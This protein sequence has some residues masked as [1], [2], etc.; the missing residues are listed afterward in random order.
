MRRTCMKCKHVNSAPTAGITDACPQCGMLYVRAAQ[1]AV[2]GSF[3]WRHKALLGVLAVLL[4]WWAY[5]E[6]WGASA[7]RRQSEASLGAA[8]ATQRAVVFNSGLDGSVF[9]VERYLRATLKD[10]AS[11]EFVEWSPVVSGPNNDFEVR[12]KYRAKNGFGG[13]AVE[14]KLFRLDASGSVVAVSNA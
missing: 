1:D 12:V 5:Q 14:Q 9:Q 4:P 10:P 3:D 2:S 6:M 7:K 13:Y 8:L 11:L